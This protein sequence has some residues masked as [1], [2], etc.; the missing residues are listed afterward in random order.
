MKQLFLLHIFI[1]FITISPSIHGR[2]PRLQVY[3]T[4]FSIDENCKIG[5]EIGTINSIVLP[6]SMSSSITHSSSNEFGQIIAL[7]Y[8]LGS[9][10]TLFSV[11][12]RKG[13]LVTKADIDAEALCSY[14]TTLSPDHTNN[15]DEADLSKSTI[16]INCNVIAY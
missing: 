15:N 1:H 10:S 4:E 6:N 13:I 7:N 12:E 9:P 2:I 3:S 14:V 11:D 8:K 16:L 5:T